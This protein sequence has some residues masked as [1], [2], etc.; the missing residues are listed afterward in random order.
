MRGRE[1]GTDQPFLNRRADRFI[2]YEAVIDEPI[3]DGFGRLSLDDTVW[4]ITGPDLD[5]GR[6][7]RVVGSDGPVLKVEPV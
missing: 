3:R 4:R 1:P 5:A 7:V 6:R 2:G